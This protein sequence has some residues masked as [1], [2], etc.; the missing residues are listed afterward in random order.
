M[1]LRNAK[2]GLDA[3]ALSL[4]NSGR[5]A[6][7]VC[8]AQIGARRHYM[9]PQAFHGQK[10][11]AGLYTDFYLNGGTVFANALQIVSRVLKI[12]VN[13][14]LNRAI[15]EIPSEII[16]S[17]GS[18]GL[19]YALARKLAK[20]RP[21][22]Q[23]VMFSVSREFARR[24]VRYGIRPCQAVYVFNSA[25]L[26]ILNWARQNGVF[27]VLDQTSAA[28]QF[29]N[30][31]LQQ[32][33][34]R[35]AGWEARPQ[36]GFDPAVVER[37]Q[38]EWATADL[39]VCGSEFVV[40]SIAESGG[41][42]QF[43]TVVPYGYTGKFAAGTKQRQNRKLRV[44]YC[45]TISL[46]KGIPYLLQAL[47]QFSADHVEVRFA[48]Q[49]NL[50][51]A[52]LREHRGSVTFTGH[53]PK[54]A[55]AEHWAWADVFVFPSLCEGSAMVCYEAM[56]AGLPV[57][58]TANAGSM[59]RDGVDGFVVPIRDASAIAEKLELFLRNDALRTHMAQS[60][61][62]RSHQFSAEAYRASLVST[63]VTAMSKAHSPKP[64]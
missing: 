54:S 57:I 36:S 27:S 50:N 51:P 33:L 43:C 30:R 61:L 20:A 21:G 29:E 58:T 44:L 4:K 10:M 11:L 45:G 5:T 6:A 37:E 48:G 64:D 47:K 62:Q 1:F 25:G 15:P 38:A 39:I 52:T 24:T 53:L 40:N 49:V 14:A 56:A 16:T 35:W 7:Q 46:L 22:R 31:I 42:S 59:V 2:T 60:A 13:R 28:R 34:E 32:E 17:F 63:V 41:P 23:R 26:E 55:L 3:V 18:L 12:N 19:R 9:V 8:I